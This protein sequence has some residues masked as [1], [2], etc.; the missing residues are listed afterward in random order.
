MK[1]TQAGADLVT[2]QHVGVWTG[3]GVLA[4]IDGEWVHYLPR[5]VPQ[6]L[7]MRASAFVGL[8]QPTITIRLVRGASEATH[9]TQVTH[10]KKR[11]T[12]SP[13]CAQPV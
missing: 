3:P 13:A 1:K 11:G 7:R 6:D 4:L 9:M 2:Q 10:I 5:D 8:D 12:S